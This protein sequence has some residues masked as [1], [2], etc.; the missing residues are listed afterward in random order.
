MLIYECQMVLICVRD[1]LM[2]DAY[3]AV[4]FIQYKIITE[5]M[6]LAKWFSVYI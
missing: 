6:T 2:T 1:T 3:T 5:H 4:H